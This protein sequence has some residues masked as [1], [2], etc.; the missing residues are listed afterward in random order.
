MSGHR[1]RKIVYGC[2]RVTR[3]GGSLRKADGRRRGNRSR[4]RSNR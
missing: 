3:A 4:G 1:A 2:A